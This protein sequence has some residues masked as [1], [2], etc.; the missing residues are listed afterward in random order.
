MIRIGIVANEASGDILGAGLIEALREHHPD[1][2]AEGIA[3]DRMLQAGCV[4]LFPMEKF[5]VMGLAEIAAKIPE[6]LR[7]RRQLVRHFLANP[8]D[9]FIGLDAP[10]FNLALERKLKQAGIPTVHYTSP[11]IW[12]W[13]PKRI[14]KIAQSV[15]LML[16]L[17]PFEAPLYEAQHIPVRYV[18]HPLAD[19]IPLMAPEKQAARQQLGL[20][21]EGTIIALL[22]GSRSSE[23]AYIAKIFIDTAVWCL[24]QRPQLVFIAPMVNAKRRAQFEAILKQTAPHLPVHVVDGQSQLAMSAADVVLS[25]SGTATLE[26]ALLKRPLV[27]AHRVAPLSYWIAKRLVTVQHVALPNILA[28]KACVPEFIQDAAVPEHIGAAIFQWLDQ[29]AL[30]QALQVEY[31]KIHEQLR[32]QASQQAAASILELTQGKLG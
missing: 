25:A 23:L 26:T 18:G 3:G 17:F 1:L 19:Q 8:P 14:V 12:A 21:Q 15:N 32:C 9:V 11:S 22:P 30:T 27:V 7:I 6:L 24:M 31:Q 29:P 16:T 10:D 5:A 28:G 4:S 20:S 13:R 2:I